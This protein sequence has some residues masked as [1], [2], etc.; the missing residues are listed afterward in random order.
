MMSIG[1]KVIAIG[2][3]LFLNL[4]ITAFMGILGVISLFASLPIVIV[5]LRR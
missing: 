4:L 1:Q 3:I 2:V 5:I